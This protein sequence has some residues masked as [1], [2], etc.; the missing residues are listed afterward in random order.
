M[1]Q[2]PLCQVT[3]CLNERCLG[4]NILGLFSGMGNRPGA[5]WPAG[6]F[7]PHGFRRWLCCFLGPARGHRPTPTPPALLW[8][9]YPHLA[10]ELCPDPAPA[11][12]TAP[13]E[14]EGLWGRAHSPPRQGC[15]GAPAKS[16]GP[17]HGSLTYVPPPISLPR[18]VLTVP[19]ASLSLLPFSRTP[20]EDSVASPTAGTLLCPHLSPQGE[21]SG[22]AAP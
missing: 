2:A 14:P 10:C 12:S 15:L 17:P 8:G 13:E 20:V 21:A 6:R 1:A 7:S 9:P 4:K 16:W 18:S 11:R 22:E 3:W 5:G 19:P